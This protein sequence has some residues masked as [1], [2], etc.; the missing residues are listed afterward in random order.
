MLIE[1]VMFLHV[2]SDS[3]FNLQS[4]RSIN[5]NSSEYKQAIIN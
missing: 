4:T 2:S 3:D 5:N 1:S